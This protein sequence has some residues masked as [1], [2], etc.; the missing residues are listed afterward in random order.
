[1]T[2]K[3]YCVT[4]TPGRHLFTSFVHCPG[5]DPTPKPSTLTPQVYWGNGCQIIPPHD[6][7]I[8]ASIEAN[9]ELWD[10]PAQLPEK[11]VC[12]CAWHT[13]HLPV[14]FGCLRRGLRASQRWL[15]CIAAVAACTEAC[16]H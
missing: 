10:L 9:L 1:M 2:S 7:G 14:C 15:A 6:A 13:L 11:L 5:F 3:V 12:V 16:V 8:A 4:H